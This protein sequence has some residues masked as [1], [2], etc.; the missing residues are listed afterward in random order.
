MAIRIKRRTAC[1]EI[2]SAD[3]LSVFCLITVSGSRQEKREREGG[4]CILGLMQLQPPAL[5]LPVELGI[6]NLSFHKWLRCA[7]KKEEAREREATLID[8]TSPRFAPP[9]ELRSEESE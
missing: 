2:N 5:P 9:P 3:V 7:L 4:L 1:G 6:R 8:H